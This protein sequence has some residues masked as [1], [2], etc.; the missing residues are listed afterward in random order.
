MTKRKLERAALIL[1]VVF[2]TGGIVHVIDRGPNWLGL[3]LGV[4]AAVI[5]VSA[6]DAYRARRA[7]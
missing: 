5:V 7:P 6:L 1:A 4:G 2:I 3:V